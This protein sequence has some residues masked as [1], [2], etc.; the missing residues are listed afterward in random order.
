M[1]IDKN[2]GYEFGHLI[3]SQKD[4]KTML[5][6]E[7]AFSMTAFSRDK[8]EY[9][10]GT[11]PVCSFKAYQPTARLLVTSCSGEAGASGAAIVDNQ[12]TN[13]VRRVG[14]WVGGWVGG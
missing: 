1:R 8:Y 12:N 2:L 6:F 9:Q 7:N 11:D 4:I 13:M 3:P 14:G 10:A 5:P